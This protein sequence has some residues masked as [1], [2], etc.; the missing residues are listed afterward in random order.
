[1]SNYSW[2]I[3]LHE[4]CAKL[5]ENS[6][7]KVIRNPKIESSQKSQKFKQ[8]LH[9]FAESTLEYTCFFIGTI[10]DKSRNTYKRWCNF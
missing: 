6:K 2:P 1:M 7:E 5:N 3:E 10:L 9:N 4:Q 8:N